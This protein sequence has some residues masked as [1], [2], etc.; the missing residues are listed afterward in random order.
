MPEQF[1]ENKSPEKSKQAAELPLQG[2][3]G[4]AGINLTLPGSIKKLLFRFP[5]SCRFLL[6]AKL[7]YGSNYLT[8]INGIFFNLQTL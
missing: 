6:S 2:A 1:I 3:G 5:S 4:R 7:I 8:N